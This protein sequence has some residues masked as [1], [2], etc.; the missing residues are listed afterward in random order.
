MLTACGPP[1]NGWFIGS[2]MIACKVCAQVHT[3]EQLKPGMVGRCARC[4]STITKRT[5]YSLH[6]TA[7]LSLAALILYVPANVFPIL[8]L[9]MYGAS[10]E[11]TVWSGCV[12]LFQDGDWIIAVIVFLA[13]ILIPLLKLLSLFVL[14]AASIFKMSRWKIQRTW[15]Y[16]IVDSVG[17]WA[18]LDVFVVAVLV[19]LVKLQK[20]ATII[21]GAGL[22][23]FTGVVVLTLLASASFDPQLIWETE[24]IES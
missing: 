15:I 4:G 18:M 2:N 20:L 23:A 13:S 7:A 6:L 1:L 8:R 16:R 9:E 11:N 22:Y 21:P 17:R 3:G 24:E 14:V 12:R 10:S 19:S 5:S